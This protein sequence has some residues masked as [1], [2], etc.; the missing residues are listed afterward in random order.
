MFE[1]ILWFVVMWAI[2]H[3][4]A[5]F[6]SNPWKFPLFSVRKRVEW[7]KYRTEQLE[8]GRITWE[9][10]YTF[11]PNWLIAWE[12]RELESLRRFLVKHGEGDW[13]MESG[14]AAWRPEQ[15]S[16]E[17]VESAAVEGAEVEPSE[18]EKRA[19]VLFESMWSGVSWAEASAADKKMF[20]D[21]V[22]SVEMW[23]DSRV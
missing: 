11:M 20:M 9:D 17:S 1:A 19:A 8:H 12:N 23:E 14:K 21:H 3:T 15:E 6:Y 7:A 22:D 5:Y 4:I 18:R 13:D 10:W 16:A 2:C